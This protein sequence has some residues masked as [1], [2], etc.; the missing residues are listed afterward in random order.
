MS[1]KSSGKKPLLG[2]AP[3]SAKKEEKNEETPERSNNKDNKREDNKKEGR[4]G[5]GGNRDSRSTS[6]PRRNRSRSPLPRKWNDK[7]ICRD[8]LRNRCNR[9]DCKY[10]HPP[11]REPQRMSWFTLC[12]D[13]QKGNCAYDDC[14]LVFLS[15]R[16]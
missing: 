7:D 5:R 14:R 10:Y 4:S 11:D 12:L 2:N 16:S 9:R 8:F 3:D 13:Y 1:K 6:K 15:R